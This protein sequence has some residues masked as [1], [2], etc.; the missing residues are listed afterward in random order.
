[1]RMFKLFGFFLLSIFLCLTLLFNIQAS[2]LERAYL[3]LGRM[4]TDVQ[5][6]M[7]LM[8]SVDSDFMPGGEL[9]LTFLSDIGQW[10][11]EE[12][13]MDVTGV[14]SSSVDIGSWIIEEELPTTSSLEATCI[15]GDVEEEVYDRIVVENI[16]ALDSNVSYGLFFEENTNFTTSSSSGDKRILVEL[17]DGENIAISQIYINLIDS[18]GVSLVAFVS[19]S[20]TITC[21]IS[22]TNISFGIL[23]RDGSYITQGHT[24]STESSLV[25]GYYWA[26]YG[27]GDG[28]E[29]GL[30]KSTLP[31]SLI[32]STGSS[33]IDLSQNYGFGL[34]VTSSSGTVIDDFDNDFGVFGAINSG[35]TNSRLIFYEETEAFSNLDVT[36][37]AKAGSATE[38]GEYVETLTYFC[39]GLY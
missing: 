22:E 23:P 28:V 4:Q 21:N 37:G 27:Q 9:T 31:T 14:D 15:P 39:G 30:W 34:N 19:D 11:S 18:D 38:V 25:D 17:E 26:V 13:S 33:T 36:L 7:T 29:A 10:C 2:N 8:F 5:T 24:L 32:P 35:S 20:G 1:M 6:D 12:S 16:G 3:L